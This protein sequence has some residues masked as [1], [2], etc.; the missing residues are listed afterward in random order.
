MKEEHIQVGEWGKRR[1]VT[2]LAPNKAELSQVG[3][4]GKERY[5]AYLVTVKV[6]PS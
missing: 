1:D 4:R 5:I 2:N 3:E 6:K